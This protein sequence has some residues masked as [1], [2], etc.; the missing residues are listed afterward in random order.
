MPREKAFVET[1]AVDQALDL[2][3][4]QGY[5]ATSVQQLCDH[6]GLSRSSL[7]DTFGD[8]HGLLLQALDRYR[9]A[10]EAALHEPFQR[11]GFGR[12]EPPA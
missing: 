2:F 7:Y 3:W 8:K 12:A 6:V 1:A 5:G 9:A 4:L 10:Q 11:L